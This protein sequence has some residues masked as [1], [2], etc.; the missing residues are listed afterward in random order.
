[1][2]TLLTSQSLEDMSASPP[3]RQR[4]KEARPQELLDAALALFVEKGFAAARIEEVAARAG[5]SKGTLYLYYTSKEELLKAV[6]RHYLSSEIAAGA[7]QIAH[8]QGTMTEVLCDVLPVWWQRVVDSPASGV[9]KLIVTEVRNFPEL[10][11][12]YANEVVGPGNA[13]IG[14][15]IARGIR[16]GEFRA[17]DVHHAVQSIVLPMVMLCLHKHSVGACPVLGG[18]GQKIDVQ[19]F[20]RDHMQ[21]LLSGMQAP[22]PAPARA[23]SS[24]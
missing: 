16:L 6:I 10:A 23:P 24:P 20:I 17:L 1:M 2:G 4:R 18:S 8:H 3:S 19:G 11:E 5:V 21:L 14:E 15:V 12:F 9:F 22:P 13:L 7:E